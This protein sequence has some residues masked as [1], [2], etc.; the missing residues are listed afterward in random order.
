MRVFSVLTLFPEFFDGPL[1]VSMMKRA[2]E[3]NLVKVEVSN[4]RDWSRDKHR[5]TDAHPYGGG[6]G[7]V[8]TPQPLHDAIRAQKRKYRS[9]KVVVFSAK[10]RL[11]DQALLRDL[12]RFKRFV[13]V[14]GHYEGIDERIAAEADFELS[15]GSY[16]VTGGEYACLVLIDGITRLLKGVLHNE[17]SHRDESFENGLLE[18]DQYTRPEVFKGRRVPEVLLSGDHAKIRA[19]RRESSERNTMKNRPDLLGKGDTP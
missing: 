17:A 5:K 18:Y 12:S 19:W 10:G 3:R 4:I 16:V 6:A 9:A 15:M 7:M 8:M 2:L 13:L 1:R 11:I 14:A